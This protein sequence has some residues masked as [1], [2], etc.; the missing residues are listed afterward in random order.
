MQ[1]TFI[2]YLDPD[3]D[4]PVNGML[5]RNTVINNCSVV[6]ANVMQPAVGPVVDD[7]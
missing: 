6:L 5:Y 7:V 4:F 3:I 2:D 1:Y